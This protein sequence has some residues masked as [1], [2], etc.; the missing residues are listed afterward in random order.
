LRTVTY[1]TENE[2]TPIT[3]VVQAPSML[4]NTNADAIRGLVPISTLAR[5]PQ[6]LLVNDKVPAKDFP[7]FVEWAR[8]Q[9]GGVNV[10]VAGP[11]DE[12]SLASLARSAN[13]NVV[14]VSYR[15]Q[16]LALTAVLGGE[17]SVLLGSVSSTMNEFIQQGRFKV[18]GVT[19]AEP[20]AAVPGGVP[21]GRFVPGY[22]QDINYALWAPAGTPPD[23]AAKLTAS[24]RQAL[25]EPGMTE[26]FT[27]FSVPLA[28]SGPAEV[29]RILEREA[30][31]L[32]R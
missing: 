29:N 18:I 14:V 31:L 6:V 1:C 5:A 30:G 4:P 11:T 19:S 13:L 9:P 28:V 32:L 16:A 7:S 22:V 2:E 25:D 20:S 27:G 21:I 26:K 10:A 24:V 3:T 8:K 12:K 23:I 15:G 17:V